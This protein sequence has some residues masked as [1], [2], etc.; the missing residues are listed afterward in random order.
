M[1]SG[2]RTTRRV[3]PR[4]QP[5]TLD[6]VTIT[7]FVSH[8]EVT[9][10]RPSALSSNSSQGASDMPLE[11]DDHA[12]SLLGMFAPIADV[13]NA[14]SQRAYASLSRTGVTAPIQH[15]S[16]HTALI[17][18]GAGLLD[19]LIHFD[20]DTDDLSMQRIAG[21]EGMTRRAFVTEIVWKAVGS[22]LEDLRA[23]DSLSNLNAA[24]RLLLERTARPLV[25]PVSATDLSAAFSG[26]CLRWE[27]IALYCAELGLVL[28]DTHSSNPYPK[29]ATTVDRKAMMQKAF[30]FCM[31][32]ESLCERLGQ[33]ND[34]TLWQLEKAIALSTWCF[35]DD[36]YLTWQLTGKVAGVVYALGWHN[37]IKDDD[38]VPL[39]LRET[40]KRTLCEAYATDIEIATFVGRP[41]R[42]NRRY[43]VLN[44]PSDVS[45]SV[46][47]GP[48]NALEAAIA[49]LGRDGWDRDN[50]V[51]PASFAR[52]HCLLNGF[53]EETLELTLGP[54]PSDLISQAQ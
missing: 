26:E 5:S 18:E 34:I 44:L 39:Y 28:G 29:T 19:L 52:L 13:D 50:A 23:T 51:H 53:R 45:N 22:F 47:L 20:T 6:S 43:L 36:S 2:K 38:T 32:C 48:T 40:R 49:T 41:P 17:A 11:N 1:A 46:T 12:T 16:A 7:S 3:T 37:G 25:M 33:A 14:P 30:S 9:E 21:E 10:A 4:Q 27:T 24:S 31:Q 15:P 8:P 42:L 35:G 54:A